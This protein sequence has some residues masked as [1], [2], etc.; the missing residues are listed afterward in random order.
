MRYVGIYIVLLAYCPVL[1]AQ[2]RLN[3]ND[4][5]RLAQ[6]QSA[7]Y[8]RAKNRWT[9]QY[10]AYRT[11]QSSMRPR[12][13]IRSDLPDLSRTIIP[14]VQNDG[15]ESF[16]ARSLVS[17]F[18]EV[19]LEQPILPTGG[20]FFVSS[21]LSR[22]DVLSPVL[23]TSYLAYPVVMGIRQPL[24]SYNHL[25]WQKRIE[26]LRLQES[27][28]QYD[29]EMEMI[30]VK[31]TEM[32]FAALLAQ[33]G[34]EIAEFNYRSADTLFR[35]AQGRFSTGRIAEIDLLDVELYYLN[36][37]HAVRMAQYEYTQQ[38]LQLKNFLHLPEK[39]QIQLSEPD[40]LPLLQIDER[41]ALEQA[42]N[43]RA[44]TLTIQRRLLEAERDI[45]QARAERLRADVFLS[46]GLTNSAST[47]DATYRN[48]QDQERLRISLEVPIVDWG[49][50]KSRLKTALANYELVRTEVEIEEAEFL[51]EVR[52]QLQRL[53]IHQQQLAYAQRASDV[54]QRRYEIA[55]DRFVA[56]RITLS[57]LNNAK[58]ELYETQRQYLNSLQNLW[59]AYF[60]LRMLTL[61][62]FERQQAIEY[63]LP[64]E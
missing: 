56:G 39:L 16:R 15:S 50:A 7:D 6:Q 64:A 18:V 25:L 60:V 44:K 36:S 17:S 33:K 4:A 24:W 26:P 51:Q 62:D 43:N 52:L 5:I 49:R 2:W 22:L 13:V 55:L 54:A 47:L 41:L 27:R 19:A 61:Y 1:Q 53:H 34:L 3:L 9:N 12:L 63:D 23:S 59:N 21:Q 45:M 10:W 29:E 37:Q 58:Q 46:F 48:L 31:T 14:V 42:R 40:W 8:E 20:M 32:Y 30:A 38:I 11:Y 35:I 57:E 28:R